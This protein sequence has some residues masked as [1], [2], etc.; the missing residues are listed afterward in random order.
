VLHLLLES[1]NLK[2]TKTMKLKIAI[3]LFFTTFLLMPFV[4]YNQN[5]DSLDNKLKNA[6]REI[7]TEAETC[8]LIT[9]DNEGR[10]TVR[11]MDTI[12]PDNDFTVWFGTNPKSRKVEQ[13]QKDPRVTLYYLEKDGLGYVMIHGIAKIVDNKKE[14]ERRFKAE[15]EGFYPNYPEG[16]V[17]I[18][19]APEWMEV[20]NY[21]HG[22]VGD[23]I[24]WETPKVIFDKK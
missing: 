12:L 2:K 10:P 4:G 13:I 20:I 8:A 24:T 7:M 1:T 23:P 5:L 17:L 16:F 15:W 6:A 11:T 3:Y 22:V 9:L 18:K 19:V 14:K 21:K